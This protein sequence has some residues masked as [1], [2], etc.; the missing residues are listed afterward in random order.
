MTNNQEANMKKII[1]FI[2]LALSAIL[3]LSFTA[4]NIGG[5]KNTNSQTETNTN[6]TNTNTGATDSNTNTNTNT[7]TN[8]TICTEHTF[9][10][11]TISKQPNCV[12]IGEEKSTC[13][14]CG[15]TETRETQSETKGSC[16]YT[17][18]ATALSAGCTEEGISARI[19]KV[20]NDIQTKKI[21]KIEHTEEDWT[22]T[23]PA[24]CLEDGIDTCNCRCAETRVSEKLGHNY[25]ILPGEAPTD[26]YMGHTTYWT[27]T[28][29]KMESAMY[30]VDTLDTVSNVASGAKFSHNA[31]E[32]HWAFQPDKYLVD[33][34]ENTGTYSPKGQNYSI[35]MDYNYEL[36]VTSFKIVCNGGGTLSSGS[37]D[38]VY[39]VSNLEIIFWDST[40]K[41]VYT[42]GQVN[43]SKLEYVECQP[44][45]FASRIE[46]KL[47][48]PS[49]SWGTD[50]LWEVYVYAPKTLASTEE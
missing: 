38:F 36:Y 15:V 28:R 3:V 22:P 19:C 8:N 49:N 14:V 35:F 7:S 9:D 40:G 11:W 1:L 33:G 50:F 26:T 23:T 45:V 5:N 31:P 16:E 30:D 21:P 20:C 10:S 4:C 12:G 44:N 27:C 47:A 39:N 25:D 13:T 43:T 41:A 6:I 32:G 18:W 2:S 48:E 37:T 29:C 34:K 46:I 42:T 17:L 24:T